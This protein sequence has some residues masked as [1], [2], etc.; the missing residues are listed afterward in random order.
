MANCRRV[1]S[2]HVV[3]GLVTHTIAD[4]RSAELGL[5]M[6][7]TS[8]AS[9]LVPK[10]IAL[11]FLAVL[12]LACSGDDTN[13]G[14]KSGSSGAAGTGGARATGG[15]AGVGVGGRG[16]SAGTA[17][18]AGRGTTGGAGGASGGSGP[19]GA[20][21]ASG[22]SGPA[23][24]AGGAGGGTGG[25][26]T[27]A[28]AGSGGTGGSDIDASGGTGGGA[29]RDGPVPDASCPTCSLGLALYWRFDEP[30]NATSAIDSSGNHFDGAYT[31]VTGAPSASAGLPPVGF[32]DPF[33]RA[34]VLANQQ[35]V[36][37]AAAPALLKAPNN[38]SIAV[39]YR[40][41]ATDTQGS[42]IL[43]L[44]DQYLL[45]LQP[46][47]LEWT[48]Q[49]FTGADAGT[50]YVHC[51]ATV[52]GYLDGNW[53]HLAAVTTPAGMTL[54][55]DGV[56][57]CTN[58]EGGDIAYT[59]GPDLWVGRHGTQKTTFDF[60]GNLDDLRVYNR[61]LS[62]GEVL[63]L[64]Q[65]ATGGPID[66]GTIDAAPPDAAPP[67]AA[68]P[69]TGVTTPDAGTDAAAPDAPPDDGGIVGTSDA[70][71]GST[72]DVSVDGGPPDV[73]VDAGPPDVSMG[74]DASSVDAS[75]GGADEVA[76]DACPCVHG[77]CTGD[78]G[79][80][81]CA[82]GF[83]GALCDTCALGLVGDNCDV[84]GL[85]VYWK[86]DETSGTVA[87]DSS[88]HH[89]DG[90]YVSSNGVFPTA[91]PGVVP[92]AATW[93]TA[94]LSFAFQNTA[95]DGGTPLRQAVQIASAG[96]GFDFVKPPNNFTIAIWY[97]ATVADLDTNGSELVSMGDHY[98]LRLAKGNSV[99]T[100]GGAATPEFRVEFD[101]FV[102]RLTDGGTSNTF[103]T[104]FTAEAAQSAGAPPWLDGNWHHVAAVSSSLLG[105]VIY[106]DGV[107]Q[108]CTTFGNAAFANFDVQYA[109]RG[110]DFWVGRNGNAGTGSAFDFQG[111]L[112]E[113]RLYGRVLSADEILGLAQGLQ[114][115][116]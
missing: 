105:M 91:A 6:R 57:A 68:P 77:A 116:P 50:R 92:P 61:G 45:R 2:S 3:G 84:T 79:A 73:S 21:G 76:I 69:D 113:V 11:L 28:S 78:G 106:L 15:S 26:D 107:A 9:T 109:G 75:E 72:P 114:L 104:C 108:T 51:F 23:G 101:K 96:A 8:I 65:G 44:G 103:V 88:G 94:S 38:L 52:P 110:S 5:N 81:V 39:W 10:G 36:Q 62:A 22:G 25:A 82:T 80:C 30:A 60:D 64:F 56:A 85:G 102:N 112:D 83:T 53:H 95:S 46:S 37:L 47:Q 1:C 67:D 16:G 24:G 87:V 40:A 41:T 32:V 115:P 111:N 20:A 31:G 63:G 13:V 35:A 7:A 100:D 74:D 17:G 29:G 49:V 70:N 43:S 98:V 89:L 18:G 12:G 58:T 55:F 48:K 27:D 90:T 54:Y 97:K 33:S 93:D 99:P 14:G 42:E 66:A 59:R 19:A 34:F 86:F 4:A 71:D